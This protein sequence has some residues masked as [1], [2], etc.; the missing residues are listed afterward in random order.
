MAPA[1][2]VIRRSPV[3]PALLT[4]AAALASFLGL[5]AAGLETLFPAVLVA[6]V[7][8]GLAIWRW[9]GTY[10]VL[11]ILDGRASVSGAGASPNRGEAVVAGSGEHFEI[12]DGRLLHV[13]A[14][15][16][17]TPLPVHRRAADRGQWNTMA[18]ALERAR[19]DEAPVTPDGSGV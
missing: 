7:V 12:E 16:T 10:F 4:A 5:W 9:R 17:R 14:D 11:E 6:V 1:R 2:F 15:G 3:G 13:S 8:L 18:S 19:P